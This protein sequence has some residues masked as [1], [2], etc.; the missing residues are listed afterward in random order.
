MLVKYRKTTIGYIRLFSKSQ[1]KSPNRNTDPC[2]KHQH[3]FWGTDL[4]GK[5][6][7]LLSSPRVQFKLHS[8]AGYINA[9][10]FWL[11][12][13]SFL[14]YETCHKLM[15]FDGF[16]IRAFVTPRTVKLLS[17]H[18][19]ANTQAGMQKNISLSYSHS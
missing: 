6:T 16:T 7:Q 2:H 9:L 18:F 4:V 17:A 5:N 10:L 14:Q 11:P 19:I 1:S 15:F 13:N 12:T 3:F 8:L